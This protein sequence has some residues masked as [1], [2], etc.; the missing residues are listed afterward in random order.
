MKSWV[1]VVTVAPTA[2]GG[3]R[4]RRDVAG[5]AEIEGKPI[6]TA[7]SVLAV[8]DKA[9]REKCYRRID[10]LLARRNDLVYQAVNKNKANWE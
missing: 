2:P 9:F 5:S 8:G 7:R 1:G 10:E 3:L 6:S 4:I